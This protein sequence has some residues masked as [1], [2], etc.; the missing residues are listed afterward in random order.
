MLQTFD[1]IASSP[2]LLVP[3]GSCSVSKSC[4]RR[5]IRSP[6]TRIYLPLRTRLGHCSEDGK[7]QP[8]SD[9]GEE[10]RCGDII[11][12]F[13]R[14]LL[15]HSFTDS[16]DHW[17]TQWLTHPLVYSPI[18]S[19]THSVSPTIGLIDSSTASHVHTLIT[20]KRQK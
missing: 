3:E 12:S 7:S 6:H 15:K 14:H 10:F 13:K 20:W 8:Q 4:K 9:R 18:Y 19:P 1:F 16:L 5:T 17:L 2:C 11:L